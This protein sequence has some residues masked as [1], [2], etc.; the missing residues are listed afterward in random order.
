MVAT[1]PFHQHLQSLLAHQPDYPV[2]PM[3]LRHLLELQLQAVLRQRY[4]PHRH[5]PHQY[6]QRVLVQSME[7]P[8]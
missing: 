8:V 3:P 7:R 5:Q 4:R 2:Q 1:P 6:L